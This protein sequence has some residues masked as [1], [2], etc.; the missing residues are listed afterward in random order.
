[1]ILELALIIP[2]VILGALA[3]EALHYLAVLPV[4]EDVRIVRPTTTRLAVEFDYY[5]EPWWHRYADIANLS[6]LLV[7]LIVM[8]LASF[9]VG[10]PGFELQNAFV[11]FGWLTFTFGGP[12]DF[13]RVFA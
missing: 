5:D 1:M 8:L 3:H 4:A 7:G 10:L 2:A 11:F 6:P 9:T 13:A 12:A